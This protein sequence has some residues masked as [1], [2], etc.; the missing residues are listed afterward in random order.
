[1]EEHGDLWAGA[2]A[3]GQRIPGVPDAD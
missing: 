1:V 3:G 2:L